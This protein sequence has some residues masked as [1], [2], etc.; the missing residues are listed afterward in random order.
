MRKKRKRCHIIYT[1]SNFGNLYNMLYVSN[2]TEEWKADRKDL[3][4]KECYA[5]VYNKSDEVCSEI[6]LIGVEKADTI[7]LTRTF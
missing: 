5:Y 3:Q 6:G 2:N 7:L 1:K 4:N